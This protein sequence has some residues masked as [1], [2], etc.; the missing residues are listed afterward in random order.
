MKNLIVKKILPILLVFAIILSLGA[1]SDQSWIVKTDSDSVPIGAYIYNL[2]I[3]DSQVKSKVENTSESPLNQKIKASSSP[4]EEAAPSEAPSDEST[5]DEAA[6]SSSQSSSESDENA[7]SGYDWVQNNALGEVKNI[8]AVNAK[9]AEMNIA[10]SDEERQKAE[11]DAESMWAYY[12]KSLQGLGV[13][14]DSYLL[15]S[16]VYSAKSEKLFSAIYDKDGTKAVSDDEV[17]KHFLDNYVDYEYISKSYSKTSSSSSSGSS[18]GSNTSSSSMTDEEKAQLETRFQEYADRINSGTPITNISDEYKAAEGLEK[19]PLD[20]TPKKKSSLSVPEDV[21]AQFE[22]MPYNQALSYKTDSAQYLLYK[23]DINSDLDQISKG[24]DVR[25]EILKEFKQGE[26]DEMIVNYANTL[27]IQI[28]FSAMNKY[29]P[30][31]VE[32]KND[33]SSQAAKKASSIAAAKKGSSS[34]SGNAS[35]SDTAS[36]STK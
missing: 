26:F 10:L 28:N 14:R 22:Q 27:N 36:V 1:C 3:A 25:I 35:K 15:A 9:M 30:K 31:F 18:A 11:S 34:S 23:K 24:S 8:I 2:N 33:Q 12:A 7:M 32:K 16:G 20:T 29:N 13:A 6:S 21:K 19:S 4:S 5:S 17:S